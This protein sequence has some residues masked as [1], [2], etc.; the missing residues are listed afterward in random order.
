MSPL[1]SSLN[2]TF[3]RSL[4]GW[5]RRSWLVLLVLP[6]PAFSLAGAEGTDAA[7]II[8]DLGDKQVKGAEQYSG[9]VIPLIAAVV[10][11]GLLVFVAVAI[12][13]T[14]NQKSD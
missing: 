11:L 1:T 4:D 8:T 13:G 6:F 12:L 3:S 10:G 5:C 14:I 7:S 2:Q 9:A